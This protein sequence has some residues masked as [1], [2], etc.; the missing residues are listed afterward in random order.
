LEKRCHVILESGS[1][2]TEELTLMLEYRDELGLIDRSDGIYT[3]IILDVHISRMMGPFL[4]YVN[5]PKHRRSAI[6]GIPYGTH[7]WQVGDSVDKNGAFKIAM[8]KWKLWLRQQKEKDG[9]K[10]TIDKT[11]IRMLLT[12]VW[13][14]SFAIVENDKNT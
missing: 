7:L 13:A 9:L 8:T 10:Q 2:T 3:M 11:D 14:D 12:L 1:I 4:E 6:L 5:N